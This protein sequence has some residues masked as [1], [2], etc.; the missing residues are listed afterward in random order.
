MIYPELKEIVEKEG[1]EKDF[2]YKGYECHIRRVG[3]PYM[4]HL[5]GYIEIPINHHLYLKDYD[6]IEK[7]YDYELPA[8][9]GLTFSGNVDNSYWIGFDCN[10][11]GDLAPMYRDEGLQFRLPNDTYKDMGFVENNIKQIIDYIIKGEK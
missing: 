1:N 8:H 5:C 7:F 11:S 2:Q 4:G 9:G 10:H 3:V 6:E